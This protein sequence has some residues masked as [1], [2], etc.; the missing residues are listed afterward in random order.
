MRVLTNVPMDTKLISFWVDREMLFMKLEHPSF[1]AVIPGSRIPRLKGL[2]LLLPPAEGWR[3]A[4]L[5]LAVFGYCSAWSGYMEEADFKCGSARR[6]CVH[7]VSR[8]I[9]GSSG[10]RYCGTRTR[11]PERGVGL[12]SWLRLAEFLTRGGG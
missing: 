5:T 10:L 1:A 11:A 3:A 2:F 8:A 4:W 6:A 9:R 12:G 7:F